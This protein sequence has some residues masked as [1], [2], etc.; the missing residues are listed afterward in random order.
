[1]GWNPMSND[2]MT[3][4]EVVSQGEDAGVRVFGSLYIFNMAIKAEQ[5]ML[6]MLD[7]KEVEMPGRDNE[8]Q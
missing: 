4:E 1:M 5:D 7:I 8:K 3:W 2:F 6:R